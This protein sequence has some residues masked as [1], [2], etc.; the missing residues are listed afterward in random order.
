MNV[1][2][3]SR[4]L[5]LSASVLCHLSVLATPALPADAHAASTDVACQQA[6]SLGQMMEQQHQAYPLALDQLLQLNR[7]PL[8]VDASV[9][10]QL[11]QALVSYLAREPVIGVGNSDALQRRMQETGRWARA[12]CAALLAEADAFDNVGPARQT[13]DTR[14]SR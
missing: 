7:L 10:Q 2:A 11:K 9:Q 8:D 3:L 13:A 5:L 4:H 1:S 12:E 14:S 6:E